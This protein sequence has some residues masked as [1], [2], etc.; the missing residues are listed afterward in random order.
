M[1]FFRSTS[2]AASADALGDANTFQSALWIAVVYVG[3]AVIEPSVDGLVLQG[4]TAAGL[5]PLGFVIASIGGVTLLVRRTD[6]VVAAEKFRLT[7][8]SGARKAGTRVGKTQAEVIE[9]RRL[10]ASMARS[11][12]RRMI[13]DQQG[14]ETDCTNWGKTS[15]STSFTA[16]CNPE[17]MA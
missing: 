13:E 4:V 15:L 16:S 2:F 14:A 8:L 10:F 5:L 9:Q 6:P 12:R 17:P 11:C 1:S 7:E 3:A